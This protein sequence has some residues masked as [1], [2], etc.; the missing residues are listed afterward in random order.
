MDFFNDWLKNCNNQHDQYFP[1]NPDYN[2]KLILKV[3]S[4]ISLKKNHSDS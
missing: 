3:M 2:Q 4:P 1:G